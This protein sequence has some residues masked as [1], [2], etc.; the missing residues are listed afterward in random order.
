MRPLIP[1][2]CLALAFGCAK[3]S[4]DAKA[5]SQFAEASLGF[6]NPKDPGTAFI[7]CTVGLI[8]AY[9]YK[10]AAE[11]QVWVF[12][13][14]S[15][16]KLTREGEFSDPALDGHRAPVISQSFTAEGALLSF[17]AQCPGASRGMIVGLDVLR[18]GRRLD[19]VFGIIQ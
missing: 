5:T 2:L 11:L 9:K 10:D 18:N 7:N 13:Y 16:Q 15:G 14:A 12:P 17:Q 6:T 8:P 4:S 19:R 3:P 1:V